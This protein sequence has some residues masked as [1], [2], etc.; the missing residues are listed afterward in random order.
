MR[1]NKNLANAIKAFSEFSKRENHADYRFVI[2]GKKGAAYESLFQTAK[3]CGCSEKVIFPGYISDAEKA[4]I[5]LNATALVFVS[6]YEGFGI[7][8]IESM[9]C[10]VPVITSNT[11]SM[12]EIGRDASM[13]V[14]PHDVHSI[15]AAMS[16]IVDQPD[17]AAELV[18]KGYRRAAEYTLAAQQRCFREVL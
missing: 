18:E 11:S 6:E 3:D 14:D 17:F 12:Y 8:V 10:G 7:P 1:A 15:A 5:L 4:N 16:Q 2:A 13:T 9:A